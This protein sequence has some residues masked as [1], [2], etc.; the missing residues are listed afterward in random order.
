MVE[1]SFSLTVD[2]DDDDDDEFFVGEDPTK[3]KETRRRTLENRS[4][5]YFC[6]FWVK[7]SER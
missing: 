4:M 7:E 1:S 6:F 2:N 3:P 5:V